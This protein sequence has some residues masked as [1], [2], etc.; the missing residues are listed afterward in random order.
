MKRSL[1]MYLIIV[2]VCF[3]NN[4]DAQAF[5]IKTENA[6]YIHRAIKEITDVMVYDIYSPPV[7]S[8]TYA[9]IS[10][11]AYETLIHA[12]TNYISLSGQL[13][14]L[15]PMPPPEPSKEYSYTLAA[16]HAIL[17]VGKALVI[18]EEKVNAF[19]SQIIKEFKE[20][21][22]PEEIFNNSI[23]YGRQVADH[24]LAWAGKDNYKQLR[25]LPF[26]TVTNNEGS[27]KPTPPAYIKAIEPNW[28]K[29]RTFV[30]D[31]AEQFKPKP[32]P[33]FSVNTNSIF[34]KNAYAVFTKVENNT[35][36]QNEV[37]NFWD[38]NPFKMNVRGH[39]MFATKKISPNGHWMNI[40]KI[41]CQ[42]LHTD[43][44]RSAE[45][46]ACLAVTL[47]DCFISCWDEKYRSDVIRPET[48]INRYINPDW[49]PVLQTPPFPEYTS[50]HSVVST[51]A[52]IYLTKLFGDNISF[53][54]SSE[55]EFGLPPRHF[56]SFHKAANEAAISRF[57]G[58]IHYM[59]AIKNGQEEGK[60]IG[61]FVA[62]KLK[63]K[64]E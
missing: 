11:A 8:R 38:C 36:E 12:N 61:E 28:N 41:I 14:G 45:A 62:H 7:S 64:K 17:F 56:T 20:N 9:Y 34:Y 2:S 15:Q 50:G 53:V 39:V 40:T 18:S 1:L 48:Y 59:P 44:V 16:V 63:T 10:V 55:I 29:I 24:I 35:P 4:A 47:A 5:K 58:G 30:I 49:L 42:N 22:I 60:E 33:A 3:F 51:G 21:G 57:Y 43:P 13:H 32:P 54:D 52:A 19:E 27:W 23:N 31:S 46:Y 37:A 6:D 26:Y 25:T